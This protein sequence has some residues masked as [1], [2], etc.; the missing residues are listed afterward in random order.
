M[1]LHNLHSW[2]S[3]NSAT[4]RRQR[5]K[6]K[7]RRRQPLL[8]EALEDRTVPTVLF[9]FQFGSETTLRDGGQRIN[10]P[11][12]YVVLW[13]SSWG[14][15][16]SPA[17]QQ[18][19]ATTSAV[20]TGHYLDGLAQ[21]GVNTT[22]HYKA[23]IFDNTLD[24][25]SGFSQQSLKNEINRLIAADQ[26]PNPFFNPDKN[27]IF[28]MVTAPG[29][30]S[31]VANAAGYNSADL[32][33][34]GLAQGNAGYIWNGTSFGTLPL[35]D[36]C[37][38]IFSHEMAECMTDPGGRG[39]EVNPGKS[40][41]NPAPNSRQIADY[42]GNSYSYRMP[43]T[44]LVQPYWSRNDNAWL[45]TDGN[46]QMMNVKPNWTGKSFNNNYDVTINGGQLAGSEGDNL[47]IGK[48]AFGLTMT[49]NNE[50]FQMDSG[51]LRTATANIS[52]GL[53]QINDSPTMTGITINGGTGTK[54]RVNATQ[55][56]VTV[57][58][59][60]TV[61][62]E[63]TAAGTPV[64]ITG[65][66]NY[67]VNVGKAGSVKAIA[68]TININSIGTGK[69]ALN[70][71]SSADLGGT[72]TVTNRYLSLLL[73]EL[74]PTIS[75]RP[76]GLSALTL[77]TGHIGI[78]GND[79]TVKSTPSAP[80]TLNTG[81]SRDVVNVR[82]T[83]GPLTVNGQSGADAV[84]VGLDGRVQGIGGTLTVTNDLDY[85]EVIVDDSAD[86]SAR[87]VIL[88]NSNTG[89]FTVISGLIPGVDINLGRDDLKSLMI[90]AGSGIDPGPG[91]PAGGNIFRIHDTLPAFY[92]RFQPTLTTVYTGAGGDTVTIDGSTGA[93]ALDVQGAPQRSNSISFGSPTA[94]LSAISGRI[95]ITGAT[96]VVNSLT[97]NDAAST[98]SRDYI[99][100]ANFV[101][102]LDKPRIGYEHLSDLTL[103]AG[104][105]TDNIVVQDTMQVGPGRSTTIA[106][107]GGDDVFDVSRTTGTLSINA[108]GQSVVNVGNIANS[109]DNIQGAIVVT[110]QGAGN[111]VT[112]T[113]NDQ[114]A[115][116]PQQLDIAPNFFGTAFR[117]SGA[118]DIAVLFSPLGIFNWIGGSGGNT[119]NV[120][121]Q[122]ALGSIFTMGDGG[123]VV[124]VGTDANKLF[125]NG[126]RF[127]SVI[128][129]AGMDQL[130][131]RDQGTFT[132]Q[133]YELRK[134]KYVG[135]E[136]FGTL[137]AGPLNGIST[138]AIYFDRVDAVTLNGGSGGNLFKIASTPAATS[139]LINAG[140]GIDTVDVGNTAFSAP[141]NL[142]GLILGPL[143]IDGQGGGNQVTF[144]DQGTTVR[145]DY[146]L[147]AD[148]LTRRLDED[149]VPNMAPISFA[150]IQTVTLNGSSGG[151]T[152]FVNSTAAGVS[153]TV[154]GQ[155]GML[156]VFA[157]GFVFDTSNILGPVSCNG[158]ADG[159]FA[160][161]YDQFNANPQ[162]YNVSTNP[163][164]P[165]NLLV[166]S[167]GAAPVTFN[168]L[169]EVIFAD[170]LV[171]GSTLNIKGV[172]AQM[173]LIPVVANGD[174]VRL[175]SLAPNLGGTLANILGPVFID[176]YS[177]DNVVTLV[178]DDSGN[179]DLT[180]KNVTITP[181][182]G[183]TD[184]DHVVGF[185]PSTIYWRN[186][187]S[188]ASVSLL[189]GA[190]DETFAMTSTAF[191]PAISIDGGGG[192]NTLDYSQDAGPT[193]GL[194]SWYK[195]EGDANDAVGGNNGLTVGGVD[196]AQGMV[197]QAFN[198]NGVDSYVQ[199]PN[200]PALE[201]ANISV[202]AWVKGTNVPAYA[203]ILAKGDNGNLL[204]SYSLET[205]SFGGLT[206]D[207]SNGTTYTTSQDAGPAIWDGNWHHVVGTYDGASVRLYVDGAEVG[208]GSPSNIVIAYGLSNTNDLFIG[209]Y[210]TGEPRFD[211]PGLVDEL[212]VYN[213]ALSAADVQA[214]YSAGSAGKSGVAYG[215]VVNLP[216]GTATGLTGG[217]ANIQNVIGSAGNDIFVG[218]GGNVLSGGA[219]R[220]LLIAGVLAGILDG[221]EDEDIL[222]GGTLNNSSQANLDA[223]MAEW[224]R[225]DLDYAARVAN[226]RANLLA[227]GTTT[228]N[229]GGNTLNGGDGLDLF[230]VSLGDIDTLELGEQF[231]PA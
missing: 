21:Y 144:N 50:R 202:E 31:G 35:R 108:G 184:G 201:S 32:L 170:P 174:A 102:R 193:A 161:Y 130:L 85:S 71:N 64:T 120:K 222:I 152:V 28:T 172:P 136:S 36:A 208:S 75:Y 143:M 58:D 190:A 90:R 176:A 226:L 111:Y 81:I 160:Y 54:V 41:P 231:F 225:S 214:I 207:V 65:R 138:L 10:S 2:L 139:M 49:L 77:S 6:A 156:D 26:L 230:F 96:G 27:L 183:P 56:P 7:A 82:A 89:P 204:P 114:A 74:S 92:G 69:A 17:A 131:I 127:M 14:S 211:F 40:W 186:L 59:A 134:G 135:Q 175:G 220:D 173:V 221:G 158:Q 128:G 213:R 140:A 121:A 106:F 149:E 198:F 150:A 34:V 147:E 179:A 157:V 181:A 209:S 118:A 216:L 113:L 94:G 191:A 162:T 187:G 66:G 228:S 109:L 88:Y 197:G 23:L 98:V 101:Q 164:L 95:D 61:D 123:D 115:T 200:S 182:D 97:I 110:P 119:V 38:L 223:I 86:T 229:G 218:N 60:G 116:T 105:Q 11:D 203:H 177:P 37:S 112:L 167:T 122:P 24:P 87:T 19:F 165:Q 192:V 47:V 13:G 133:L 79:I 55:A 76:T 73:G 215:V 125:E 67:N 4:T 212:S 99:M 25:K 103:Q 20:V 163:A 44:V 205:N 107:S 53:V 52:K 137:L 62:V 104:A 57:N 117:R 166:E 84:I 9:P 70:V 43:N 129:G 51:Q 39:Y 217:I 3:R 148:Q 29:I 5:G 196:F 63:S 185:A 159:D 188:N 12:V 178:L 142:L 154:N 8:V 141:S 194:V 151:S 224:S 30:S 210:A 42:E 227:D 33:G 153:T 132:P 219:G 15:L 180:P 46:A 45:V 199:V 22:A 18:V 100:G 195:A 124:N 93:L 155:P 169:S 78:F 16:V 83:S 68:G 206:F 91:T 171:G 48:D 72:V 145:Q 168:N 126:Y 80:V 1:F 189:G 146:T